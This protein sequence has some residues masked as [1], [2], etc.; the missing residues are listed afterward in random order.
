M[1]SNEGPLA[2]LAR[3]AQLHAEAVKLSAEAIAEMAM[4]P[5]PPPAEAADP[6][7]N[8]EQAA[9]LVGVEPHTLTKYIRQRGLPARNI[10]GR[11]RFIRAEVLNWMRSQ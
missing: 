8:R 6:I 2:K 10:N 9:Q 7:L 1:K 3:A 4:R 5:D 11:W